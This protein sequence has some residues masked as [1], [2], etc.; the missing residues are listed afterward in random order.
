MTTAPDQVCIRRPYSV[1]TTCRCPSCVMADRRIRKTYRHGYYSPAA[2]RTQAW[3][4]LDRMLA[5]GWSP[6]AMASAT[7]LPKRYFDSLTKVLRDTGH[8]QRVGPR[9]AERIV[10]HGAPTEGRVGA[11]GTTRRMQALAAMGWTL[12]DLTGRTGLPYSTLESLRVPHVRQ[13]SPAA[14]AAVAR[15]YDDLCMTPGPSTRARSMAVRKEWAPPLAWEDIDDPAELPVVGKRPVGGQGLSIDD[16][17]HLL[18]W[19]AW[20]WPGITSRLGVTKSA[21]EHL[22]R[23]HGRLDLLRQIQLIDPNHRNSGRKA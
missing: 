16:L 19:Q 9:I 3:E 20:T 4:A 22:C 15:A 11:V 5:A 7:G 13:T 18:F 21:I 23:R 1:W 14:A 12:A 17:E 10:N 2:L 8:R 6:A